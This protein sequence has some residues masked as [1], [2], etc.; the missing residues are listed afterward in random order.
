MKKVQVL[1]IILLSLHTLSWA[2]DYRGENKVFLKLETLKGDFL[3]Y[4]SDKLSLDINEEESSFELTVDMQ[5]FKPINAQA[6]MTLWN[7]LFHEEYHTELS[8]KAD[9]PIMKL[10]AQSDT[11]QVLDINGTLFLGEGRC[12]YPW[13]IEWIQMDRFVFVDFNNKVSLAKLG[14]EIPPAYQDLLTGD[15][16]VEVLN[17]KLM[18]GFR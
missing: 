4:E 18:A 10:D 7:T 1:F 2:Q 8:Y 9:F 15:M 6:N 17:A 12:T 14:L 16:V 11:K 3:I 13:K 5:S